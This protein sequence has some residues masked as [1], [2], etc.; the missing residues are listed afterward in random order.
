MLK[1]MED[2]QRRK[3]LVLCEDEDYEDNEGV[4]PVRSQNSCPSLADFDEGIAVL[5]KDPFKTG[6]FGVKPDLNQDHDHSHELGHETQKVK[7]NL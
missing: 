3:E 4:V 1:M 6:N 7:E 5:D 2:E